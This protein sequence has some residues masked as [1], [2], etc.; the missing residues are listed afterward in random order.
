MF[1]KLR[2]IVE[3]G[4]SDE[5]PNAADTKRRYEGPLFGLTQGHLNEWI[6]EERRERTRK[7]VYE[8][9]DT[10]VRLRLENTSP[11]STDEEEKEIMWG[12]GRWQVPPTRR[13]KRLLEEGLSEGDEEDMQDNEPGVTEE[14]TVCKESKQKCVKSIARKRLKLTANRQKEMAIDRTNG[15]S[16]DK[17]SKPGRHGQSEKLTSTLNG[18]KTIHHIFYV[19]QEVEPLTASISSPVGDDIQKKGLWSKRSVVFSVGSSYE[20]SMCEVPVRSEQMASF[21]PALK[22][23]SMFES[24]NL[25]KAIRV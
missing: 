10:L 15:E 12:R 3:D 22:F 5:E 19:P 2:P 8:D 13:G 17:S 21:A 6:D 25:E 4:L 20:G 23:E 18:L 16:E 7:T 14:S 1:L 24:G 11:I 9:I